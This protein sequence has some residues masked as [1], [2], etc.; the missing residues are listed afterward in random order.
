LD[1][2]SSAVRA[3]VTV[4][5]YASDDRIVGA[6]VGYLTLVGTSVHFKDAI[7][8]QQ[9]GGFP[10]GGQRLAISLDDASLS[11]VNALEH[12]PPEDRARHISVG[13]GLMPLAIPATGCTMLKIW[14]SIRALCSNAPAFRANRFFRS[15]D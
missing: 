7:G 9:I 6:V 8:N 13:V 4:I 5:L 3:R 15:L 2:V 14:P 12:N 10:D 11:I 1:H